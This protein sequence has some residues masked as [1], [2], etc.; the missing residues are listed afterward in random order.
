MKK[1]STMLLAT[2]LLAGCGILYRQPI[3]Q[4]N[5]LQP[6]NVEQLRE[7]MTKRQV[8]SLLGTPMVSDPFHES[9]W[10]YVATQ[11]DTRVGG[12]EI[13]NLTVYFEGDTVARWEGEYFP[14]QD[15]ELGRKMARFGNLPREKNQRGGGR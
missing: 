9:R 4:G 7:G 11:R 12:P 1:I 6:E 13:K 14:K 10:D 2:S 15:E 5:L 3:Y 8:G